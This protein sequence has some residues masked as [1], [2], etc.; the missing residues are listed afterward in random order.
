[1]QKKDVTIYPLFSMPLMAIPLDIK[2]QTIL[3]FI[4]QL[5]YKKNLKESEGTYM[6]KSIKILEH[7]KLKKEKDIFIA[8]IKIYLN[9]LSYSKQYK[10]LNSWATKTLK[11]CGSQLHVHRNSWLSAV[12]YPESDSGFTISFTKNLP[13]TS[14][15]G[16]D[17]DSPNNIYSCEEWK[18]KPSKNVLLIFPSEMYHKIEKNLSNKMRYSLAFNINPIGLFKKDSDGEINYA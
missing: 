7:Q 2:S 8:A 14:F 9:I 13:N 11:N 16:L 15:F 6:S 12:Y 10:I 1:M 5:S 4:K 18:I 17:Y 3:N